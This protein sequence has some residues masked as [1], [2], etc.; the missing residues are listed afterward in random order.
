VND[1]EYQYFN[2]II[3]NISEVDT[4]ISELLLEINKIVR[5]GI[6]L[7]HNPDSMDGICVQ[8]VSDFLNVTNKI[9]RIYWLR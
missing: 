8:S 1:L 3:C 7:E 5:Q 4:E 2:I 9:Y 6:N